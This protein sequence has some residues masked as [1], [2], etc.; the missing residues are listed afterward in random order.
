M[1]LFHNISTYSKFRK[2]LIMCIISTSFSIEFGRFAIANYMCEN[3]SQTA[4]INQVSLTVTNR[5]VVGWSSSY[6]RMMEHISVA[7]GCWCKGRDD[8]RDG[9]Y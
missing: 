8:I 6:G 2:Y 7:F 9:I 5:I 4:N 3:H 1:V